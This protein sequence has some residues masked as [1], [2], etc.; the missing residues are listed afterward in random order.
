[1]LALGLTLVVLG[2]LGVFLR[3]IHAI[4]PAAM[5]RWRILLVEVVVI[6]AWVLGG[7]AVASLRERSARAAWIAVDPNASAALPQPRAPN[8]G[9]A[10]LV[11]LASTLGLQVGTPGAAATAPRDP[12][13]EA[14][15]GALGA[16]LDSVVRQADDRPQ[17]APTE[18]RAWLLVQD[19]AARTL[20]HQLVARGPVDWGTRAADGALG[21]SP[22]ELVK[23]HGVLTAGALDRMRAGDA[24]S[25]SSALEAAGA[26][27]ASLRGRLDTPSR[28]V[29]LMLDRR[30]LGALRMLDPVPPGWEQRLDEIE[31]HTQPA[32]VLP[33]E[34]LELLAEVREPSCTLRGLVLQLDPSPLLGGAERPALNRALVW[35]GG[36]P[37]PLEDL[38]LAVDA[39]K[40]RIATPF[41]RYVQ[42]PLERPYVGL[43]AADY[44]L[45]QARNAAAAAG[46]D[47]CAPSALAPAAAIAPWSPIVEK[48]AAPLRLARMS[49]VLRAELELTRLVARART[50]RA[51]APQHGWPSDLPG[52][53]SK[54]CAPRRFGVQLDAGRAELRLVPNAFTEGEATVAFRMEA[55]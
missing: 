35:L 48:D 24:V 55:R 43:V 1:M 50:L 15:L 2:T 52:T 9:G 45:V 25:A 7:R 34:M 51:Q 46:A 49:A 36:G 21:Y 37:V 38:A 12:A 53:S 31:A 22:L 54:A 14:A 41:Y 17:A 16:Y 4:W 18:L 10:E 28:L 6:L 30:L 27:A 29:A 20:E 11:R 44:A 39:E 8:A 42:G 5:G 40:K 3:G 47:V 26:L 33:R 13:T 23:L 32:G 19:A